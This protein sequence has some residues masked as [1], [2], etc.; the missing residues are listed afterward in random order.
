MN[1]TNELG[2][3]LR[4]RRDEVTPAAAGIPVSGDRR[5]PGLRRE[6]VALLA[7]LSTDYYT[8]LEQ[9]RELHP[10]EQVVNSVSR[11]LLL[12]RHAAEYLY[13]LTQPAPRAISAASSAE[14][15]DELMGFVEHG[16]DTPAMVLGPA[17]DVLAANSLGRALY[18]DFALFDNVVR[19]VF[20][21]PVAREF[22]P[23][24]DHAARGVV[25]NL[26]ALSA[27]FRDDPS[28]IAIIGELTVQSAAF[29]TYWQRREVQPRLNEAKTL[30]HGGVGELHLHYQG[31]AV[32][33]S[34]GQHL[35]VYTAEA[36]SPSADRLTLLGRTSGRPRC[37]ACP[38]IETTP[39]NHTAEENHP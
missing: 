8:R 38:G 18:A 23:D 36:G 21:D 28:V 22:Y 4:A 16:I 2:E 29:V 17:L 31:F 26:R 5:V 10:S 11:A 25:S 3:F 34:P 33:D 12:D 19:M 37:S 6:E 9:G 15:D 24:W 7:G 20:L 1:G 30:H 32:A 39:V 14:V 13:R 35:F 27:L